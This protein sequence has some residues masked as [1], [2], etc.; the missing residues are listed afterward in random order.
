MKKY[1]PFP[2]ILDM[3][4]MLEENLSNHLVFDAAFDPVVQKPEPE[5][6]GKAQ[7]QRKGMCVCVSQSFFSP[8]SLD[9]GLAES[10]RIFGEVFNVERGIQMFGGVFRCPVESSGVRWSL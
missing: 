4:P 7:P 9:H 6:G 3:S 10:L 1:Y 5:L 8:G 2:R